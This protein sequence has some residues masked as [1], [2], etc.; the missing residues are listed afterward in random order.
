MNMQRSVFLVMTCT[1]VTMMLDGLCQENQL[2][3]KQG[4]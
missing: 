2:R 4:K 1:F 3:V